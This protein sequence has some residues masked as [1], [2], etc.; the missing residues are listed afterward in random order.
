MRVT[1]VEPARPKILEFF[2][3]AVEGLLTDA[4]LAAH[5]LDRRA[6]LGL[7]ERERDL[8]IRK[9]RLLHRH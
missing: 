6:G 1:G 3:P 7:L 9:S 2:L 4:N 8:F 5:L